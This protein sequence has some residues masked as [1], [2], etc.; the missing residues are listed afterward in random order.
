MNKK[1]KTKSSRFKA[2]SP[3]SCVQHTTE[4]NVYL[5]YDVD[6]NIICSPDT[7]ESLSIRKRCSLRIY[8]MCIIKSFFIFISNN[9]SFVQSVEQIQIM[10]HTMYPSEDN[11]S[12]VG[13]DCD[14]FLI[15]FV[16]LLLL[17][18]ITHK[19]N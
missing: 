4:L 10:I 18:P 15:Y 19:K 16:S 12:V 8:V 17:L 11:F 2:P 5:F 1:K 3:Q 14:R 13:F 6:N 9:T 7:R